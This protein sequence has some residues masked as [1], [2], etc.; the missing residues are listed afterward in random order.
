MVA[1]DVDL[2]KATVRGAAARV[3]CEPVRPAVRDAWGHV[4]CG[5]AIGVASALLAVCI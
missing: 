4:L 2:A 3:A 1:R 5:V